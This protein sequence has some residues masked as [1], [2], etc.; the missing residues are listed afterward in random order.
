MIIHVSPVDPAIDSRLITGA[1]L[2]IK[3]GASMAIS[4]SGRDSIVPDTV[5]VICCLI[6]CRYKGYAFWTEF[7]KLRSYK[8]TAAAAVNAGE[9]DAGSTKVGV[10]AHEDAESSTLL[11]EVLGMAFAHGRNSGHGDRVGGKRHR[12]GNGG[13]VIEDLSH[14]GGRRGENE[15]VGE[16]HGD[17]CLGKA[18]L[19]IDRQGRMKRLELEIRLQ[20]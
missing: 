8:L 7:S 13:V 9:S 18:G 16:L 15:E 6:R 2:V 17:G 1:A 19:G 3:R 4:I 10:L 5:D 20:S 11:K 12:G 14:G